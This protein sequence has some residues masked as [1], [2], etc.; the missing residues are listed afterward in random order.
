[1]STNTL[2]IRPSSPLRTSN[3][4]GAAWQTVKQIFQQPSTATVGIDQR[5]VWQL[6]RLTRGSDSVLP[7]VYNKLS[8]IAVSN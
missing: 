1:M 8:R 2:S 6:Y 3:I 7:A 5:D 4:F